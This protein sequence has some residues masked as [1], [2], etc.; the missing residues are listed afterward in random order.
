MMRKYSLPLLLWQCMLFQSV[1]DRK[2]MLHLQSSLG[3]VII[4]L[5][6]PLDPFFYQVLLSG[7]Y[8]KVYNLVR[9]NL[10]REVTATPIQ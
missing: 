3:S 5:L 6:L 2:S 4:S 8:R 9:W 7:S 10:E 1:T